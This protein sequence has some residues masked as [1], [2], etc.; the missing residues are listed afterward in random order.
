M[1]SLIHRLGA[2]GSLRRPTTTHG[3]AAALV[4]GW[5]LAIA[6]PTGCRS[7][8]PGPPEAGGKPQV[9]VAIP[10]QAY[11]VER[12]AGK[13]VDIQVLV[14]PG[15]SPHTYEPT[16]KQMAQL[17]R[18][19]L[20]FKIGLPFEERLVSKIGDTFRNL[21]VVDTREGIKLRAIGEWE[22][23]GEEEGGGEHHDE[24]RAGT[25]DPHIWL[26]PR[27]VKIQAEKMARALEKVDPDHAAEYAK[28]LK[29]FEGDLDSMDTKIATALAPLKG[30]EFFV[31]HPA[32]GY[33]GDAYGLRQAAVE[34]GGKQPGPKQLAELIGR[35]RKSGVKLILVQRQFS[36]ASAEAVAKAIGGAVVPTDTLA[37]DYMVNLEDLAE[38]IKA[39]LGDK[40]GQP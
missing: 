35:A 16:P 9:T 33:F 12:V 13:N 25:P 19:R 40:R 37:R 2:F 22:L 27:L 3:A 39:A 29:E 28:N 6:L 32:F 21:T 24:D 38:K 1:G 11:F 34:T 20:Y 14:E 4:L 31:F 17:A 30:Q 15:Q 36:T 18:S 7:S 23:G 10:P 5:A 26:A 8:A